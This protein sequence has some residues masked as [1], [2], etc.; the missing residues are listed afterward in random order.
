MNNLSIR[1]RFIIL[2]SVFLTGFV[3]FFGF[4]Y[5]LLMDYR[6]NSPLYISIIQKKD[7]IADVLPPPNFII[8]S[9]MVSL[10]IL[11]S[12]NNATLDP[13]VERIKVLKGEYETRIQY[14]EKQ[15]LDPLLKEKLLKQS[16][17]P[18]AEFYKLLFD[19]LVPAVQQKN[20]EAARNAIK[21]ITQ[22]FEQHRIAIDEVVKMT[23]AEA[24]TNEAKALEVVEASTYVLFGIFGFTVLVAL[25]IAYK[26]ASSIMDSANMLAK[27]VEESEA[28][29]FAARK[30]DL[31]QRIGLIG[32]SGAVAKLCVGVNS[33]VETNAIIMADIGRVLSAQAKG[34]LSQRIHN[35][36][37]GTFDT[38]KADAN[39]TSETLNNVVDDLCRVLASLSQGDLGQRIVRDYDGIFNQLKTDTNRTSDKLN[40]IV[41]DM[42]RVLAAL[43][44]GDLTQRV[45]AGYEG[46]YD[47]LKNDANVSSEKVNAV[48]DDISG[49]F[50]A[51]AQGDLSQRIDREMLGVFNLVKQNANANCDKLSSIILNIRSSSVQL[52]DAAEQVSATAQSLSQSTSEQSASVEETSASVDQMTASI[53]QN[54]DNAKV[55]DAMATK[56]AKEA[57]EGGDAVL[58]TVK[59]MKQ[60]AAKISIVDDIAYQTNLLALN[61]AI[62]AARAGEHG[63]GF[64]VVAAEVRKLAERSQ[65]AAREIGDLASDSVS[66]AERA[67]KLLEEI[68]PSIR[69]TSD[70]VQEITAA[71]DEQSTSAGQ[72]GS[73]MSQLNR[74][75]QQNASASEELA[76]TAE[77]LSAQ[78]QQLQNTIGFFS[79]AQDT[80]THS[81]QPTDNQGYHRVRAVANH[82]HDREGPTSE[83]NFKPY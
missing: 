65:E 56:A 45:T 43:A 50:A 78:A 23:S 57:T 69:K 46:I 19:E 36:Y 26:I 10:Q 24:A 39:K 83:H 81:K 82:R 33:L 5:K 71:S 66:T 55:T 3:I 20:K 14:W 29:I 15:T 28:V 72:I 30:G 27:A 16:H 42:S 76:A 25:L 77:E 17:E 79:T 40:S 68:V 48:V 6:I 44:R 18:V 13:L 74:V 22:V 1:Q 47:T 73:A 62:E 52:L 64:A 80:E 41:N 59:A 38:L 63:K 60:I 32:K 11:E 58:R 7:L 8:E 54:S 75:T 35:D 37:E 2:L 49:M 9:Y 21:K 61:A 70:L 12:E 31:T 51:L 4:A 67:G 53:S 34:D